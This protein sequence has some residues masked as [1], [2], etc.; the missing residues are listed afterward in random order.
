MVGKHS[1]CSSLRSPE[2]GSLPLHTR[3]LI[4]VTSAA[5]CSRAFSSVKEV[6]RTL[7]TYGVA[8]QDLLRSR[9]NPI[10]RRSHPLWRTIR[11]SQPQRL[12]SS[13]KSLYSNL[14]V[15]DHPWL[16]ALSSL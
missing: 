10:V 5:Y 13:S 1:S 6:S 8:W 9:A 11:A 14:S 16:T 15:T 7:S 12:K 2:L 4:Y 3:L